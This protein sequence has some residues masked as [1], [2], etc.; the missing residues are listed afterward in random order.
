MPIRT[1]LILWYSG[2]LA[3]IVIVFSVAVYSVMSWTLVNA[4]DSTLSETAEQVIRNSRVQRI[5]E[6]G[7]PNN[8]LILLPRLDI[9]RA[10]GVGVQV[11]DT[12]QTKP[13]LAAASTNIAD[14]TD[15]LDA[16]VLGLDEG[17]VYSNTVINGQPVRVLTRPMAGIETHGDGQ[18][19][20]NV[21][22]VASLATVIQARERLLAVML[23]SGALGIL[24]SVMLGM[25]LSRQALQPINRIT[26]AA[27][28]IAAT[29]D[30]S[31]RLVWDG[32]LDELGRLASVF[33]HMMDRLE[34]LFSVQR[35]FVADVSH[36]LRTPLTAIRGNLE[37]IQRY[38]ADAISMGAVESE[39][40]RMSRMVDDLLLLARADYGGL[41]LEM[42]P[43]DLD[44]LLLEVHQQARALCQNRRLAVVVDGIEPVRVN[45][46]ADRLKQLMLNL[47][48]NAIKF[49]PDGGTIGLALCQRAADAVIAVRDTGIGIAPEDQ[50]HIFDRFYQADTS[51]QRADG[52]GS[53]LGLSIARWL[54]EAHGGTI[55]VESAPGAG[56]VFTVTLPALGASPTPGPGSGR[57][58][59]AASGPTTQPIITG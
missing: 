46:S 43:V 17:R 27:A 36:E 52:D 6:F 58:A 29:D 9:F 39:T 50:K 23:G 3:V 1:R 13:A 45:G 20:A 35:R 21:Q 5:G 11:W 54:A 25:W 47:V 44:T 59:R 14:Y 48:Q 32:P 41:R 24:G 18:A 42:E 40:K 7:G 30:L 53:G 2:L 19:F 16:A 22:V 55:A 15:P 51:R 38:G 33:N 31:T 10:S 28:R 56:S 37:L 49:T 8:M 57:R 12:R 34:H 4:V 26:Q